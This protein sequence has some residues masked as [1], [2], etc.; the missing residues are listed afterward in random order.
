M[1]ELF[2]S[3]CPIYML[4]GMTWEQFWFG[5][6]GMASTFRE[7]YLLKQRA[8]NEEMWMQGLYIYRA[9]QAVVA[10]ALGSRSAKYID[11]PLDYLPKTKAEKEQEKFKEKQKVIAFLD[12]L[13]KNNATKSN[14]R[15]DN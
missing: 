1:T 13:L 8:K 6:P 11:A 10:S 5:D 15:T 7:A 9:V 2:E 12:R 14:E 4:Y 3:V